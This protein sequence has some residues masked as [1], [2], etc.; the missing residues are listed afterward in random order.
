MKIALI[1]CTSRKK[2]CKCPAKE[3]YS[4]SPNFRYLHEYAK[5]AADKIFILS[6][7]YGLVK[8]DEILEPYNKTLDDMS[9]EERFAWKEVVV[10]RLKELTD[11]ANDEFIVLAGSKYCVS[12]LDT[13]KA[14]WL[15]LKNH[16]NIKW[17]KIMKPLIALEKETDPSKALHMFFNSLK[18]YNGFEIGEVPYENGIYVMFEKGESLYGMDRIVRIGTHDGDDNLKTRLR[19]H[20]T[21]NNSDASIFRKHIGRTFLN[22]ANDP[23]LKT[24]NLNTSNPQIRQK[25]ESEIDIAKEKELENRITKYLCDNISFTCIPVE[26]EEERIRVEEGII[27]T[28]N[29]SESFRSEKDWLGNF[30]PIDDIKNSRLWNRKGLNAKAFNISEV[31][32]LIWK[33]R[34]NPDVPAAAKNR[35]KAKPQIKTAKIRPASVRCQSGT[36][37]EQVKKHIQELFRNAAVNKKEYIEIRSGDIHS[38]MGLAARMPTVCD[39]MYDLQSKNDIIVHAPP[40]GKGSTLT[41]RYMLK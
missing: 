39:A 30:C 20:F 2:A 40:K 37:K 10:K 17:I 21:G 14:H 3:L 16:S 34:F 28:L 1:T 19:N 38:Q 18:R 15:P 13:L 27:S 36:L 11:V 12:L 4:A 24:W 22:K 8:E 6:A 7:K 25:H 32:E 33:L 35:F 5:L 41:I 31:K 23:Y 9:K 26:T 29:K